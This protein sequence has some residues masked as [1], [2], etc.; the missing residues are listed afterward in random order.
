ME[1]SF[2]LLATE[3][4]LKE[5]DDDYLLAYFSWQRVQIILV[6]PEAAQSVVS[7]V[8]G[9]VLLD[10]EEQRLIERLLL[11]EALHRL[12]PVVQLAY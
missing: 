12:Q 5:V 7:P 3:N 10:V 4:V 6:L 11:G 2:V 9:E 1:E 8:I